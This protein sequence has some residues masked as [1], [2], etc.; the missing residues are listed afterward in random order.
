M[1]TKDP[2][3]ILINLKSDLTDE[4]K[5][6]KMGETERDYNATRYCNMT[7]NGFMGK[8]G[9]NP[10]DRKG[11]KNLLLHGYSGESTGHFE[12]IWH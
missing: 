8:L 2:I 6:K 1:K 10:A 9:L 12:I 11:I 3:A 5:C 4:D 7:E